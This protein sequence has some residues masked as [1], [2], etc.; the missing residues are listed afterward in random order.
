MQ[1]TAKDIEKYPK[2]HT[3]ISTVLPKIKDRSAIV[4]TI[5][6]LSGETDETI[7]T[8]ALIWGNL[9]L[10]KIVNT[11]FFGYYDPQKSGEI[12]IRRKWVKEFEKGKGLR[13]TKWGEL[14][15]FVEVILLHELT[16]WTDDRDHRDHTGEE[17]E[18][19][20]LFEETVYGYVITPRSAERY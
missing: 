5:T 20:D 19:G 9:P 18:E 6:S 11:R 17:I 4:S 15:Q 14:V 8:D 2:F 1:M 13:I 12:K 3:Y 7:V 16:H 10:I